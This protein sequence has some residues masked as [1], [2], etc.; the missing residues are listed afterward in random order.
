MHLLMENV[1]LFHPLFDSCSLLCLR[2]FQTMV[3]T[4]TV[5]KDNTT[6]MMTT[7]TIA[8]IAPL[9]RPSFFVGPG[10]GPVIPTVTLTELDWG[11]TL[12]CVDWGWTC[13]RV[14]WGWT[15]DCVTGLE[16]AVVG[17]TWTSLIRRESVAMVA[18]GVQLLDINLAPGLS[19][20]L[21]L[22]NISV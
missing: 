4:M 14:D 6:S 5:T 13:D 3:P 18:G 22:T 2:L 10:S 15:C 16:N 9:L 11:W 20:L 17:E 19:I 8:A 21:Q 12:D 7:T 1:L